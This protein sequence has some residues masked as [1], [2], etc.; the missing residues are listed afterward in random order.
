MYPQQKTGFLRISENRKNSFQNG[1]TLMNPVRPAVFSSIYAFP[2][3]CHSANTMAPCGTS[4]CRASE[5]CRL[6]ARK[7]GASTMASG[8][9]AH[10]DNFCVFVN[11]TQA[12]VP[13]LAVWIFDL[14][15]KQDVG[16]ARSRSGLMPPG[17]LLIGQ[18]RGM[19]RA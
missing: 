16:G 8:I 18:A 11:L 9:A 4:G 3:S 12:V 14:F 15:W 13:V 5:R 17:L 7:A 10:F 19:Q 1:K 6:V 2:P